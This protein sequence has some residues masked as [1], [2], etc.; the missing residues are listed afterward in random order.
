MSATLLDAPM[1][2][3]L[4]AAAPPHSRAARWASNALYGLVLLFL[5]FDVVVKFIDFPGAAENSAKMGWSV[6]QFPLLGVIAG[7]CLVLY[8]L[9]RTAP[10]GAILW[11]GYLGGAVATH[12]R[13][14]NPL[15]SYTLFPIYVGA[16]IWAALYLRDARVRALLRPSR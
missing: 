4:A 5:T 16:L 10:L 8:V 6:E 14:N 12:L 7:V 11:T 1:T 2:V 3:P 13:V 15:F 9:P